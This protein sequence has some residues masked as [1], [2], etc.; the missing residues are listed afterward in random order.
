[1][2]LFFL[3]FAVGLVVALFVCLIYEDWEGDDDDLSDWGT[4]GSDPYVAGVGAVAVE[5]DAR[6]DVRSA[7]TAQVGGEHYVGCAIQPIEYIHANGI[8]FTEGC[9]IKYATRWRNKGGITDLEKIEHFARLLIE[10]EQR[11]GS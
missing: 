3:G 11:R 1:M 2:G 6:A 8:P 10:L 4:D 9:I 7:L 5:R